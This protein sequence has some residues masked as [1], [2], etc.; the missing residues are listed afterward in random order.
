MY[1]FCRTP[2]RSRRCSKA[3]SCRVEREIAVMGFQNAEGK[4]C[5]VGQVF[6]LSGMKC[7]PEIEMKCLRW[8]DSLSLLEWE[9]VVEINGI[10]VVTKL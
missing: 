9:A 1:Q 4:M 6:L 7:E 3:A 8:R 10:H 5:R 2:E